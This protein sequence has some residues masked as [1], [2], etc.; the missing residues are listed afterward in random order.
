MDNRLN[1][2]YL[3]GAVEYK[4]ETLRTGEIIEQ[5]IETDS[6][7]GNILTEWFCPR[8]I[9]IVTR[10]ERYSEEYDCQYGCKDGA[11]ITCNSDSICDQN[12]DCSCSDCEGKNKGCDPYFV[13]QNGECVYKGVPE[14]I[15]QEIAAEEFE[16]GCTDSD[17]GKDY[18][19]KGTISYASDLISRTF[20][21][22]CVDDSRL[23]EVFCDENNIV[24]QEAY[25]C[26]NGCENG[27]CL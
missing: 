27:A 18:F 24:L 25:T 23:A 2:Y 21:D 1:Y 17:G 15:F 20:V 7:N 12:E 5:G 6:C 16:G 10:N 22:T 4:I 11:C 3:K 8:V 14:E 19:V 26:P 9:S 13:C